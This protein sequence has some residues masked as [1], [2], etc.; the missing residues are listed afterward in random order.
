M[1]KMTLGALPIWI[2]TKA[3]TTFVIHFPNHLSHTRHLVDLSTWIR[4]FS[5]VRKSNLPDAYIIISTGS[6][7]RTW[8]DSDCGWGALWWHWMVWCGWMID[9]LLFEWLLT[10]LI[11]WLTVWLSWLTLCPGWLSGMAYWLT[12][13]LCSLAGWLWLHGWMYDLVGWLFDGLLSVQICWLTVWM[14]DWLSGLTDWLADRLRKVS[15]WRSLS[16]GQPL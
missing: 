5:K 16:C 3:L 6:T 11:G 8:L 12:W 14:T 15:C 4:S 2:S 9:Y 13:L 10:V 1:T 7:G